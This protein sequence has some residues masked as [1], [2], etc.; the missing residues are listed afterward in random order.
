MEANSKGTAVALYS[1]DP[2]D[3]L[4]LAVL[5]INAVK[6]T[7]LGE[8]AAYDGGAFS[9]DSGKYLAAKMPAG[10]GTTPSLIVFDL[11]NK[12]AKDLNIQTFSD[13]AVWA[14][15]NAI[16]AASGTSI[17]KI[18]LD[19]GSQETLAKDLGYVPRNVMLHPSKPILF[20]RDEKTGFLYRLD[21]P[22]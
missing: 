16:I 22:R 21:L 14:D 4:K 2:Q 11:A 12:T 6:F 7:D 3:N 10:Q 8:A 19:T 20:F 15:N 17:L 18:H 9:Q 1:R 5:D 13:Q